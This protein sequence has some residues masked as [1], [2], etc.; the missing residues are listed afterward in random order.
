VRQRDVGHGFEGAGGAGE[1]EEGEAGETADNR[2]AALVGVDDPEAG[3]SVIDA[4]TTGRGSTDGDGKLALA[5]P[6]AAWAN[7]P[8]LVARSGP[9]SHNW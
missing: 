8:T 3:S 6:A 1:G 9:M 5:R 4:R 7:I 2:Y